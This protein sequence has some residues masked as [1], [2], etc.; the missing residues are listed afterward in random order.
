MA[1]EETAVA[2]NKLAKPKAMA[3]PPINSTFGSGEI[4][5]LSKVPLDLSRSVATE[6]IKNITNIG[7]TPSIDPATRWNTSG[8]DQYTYLR[9]VMSSAGDK[10]SRARVL[11][12]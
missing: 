6:V 2:W 5:S 11:G 12:S 4:I 8:L 7:K 9:I 3:Y 10:K 1:Y